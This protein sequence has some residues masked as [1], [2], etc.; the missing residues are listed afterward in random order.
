MLMIPE[1]TVGHT[2]NKGFKLNKI[3]AD[4]AFSCK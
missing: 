1:I 2:V 3:F 4:E